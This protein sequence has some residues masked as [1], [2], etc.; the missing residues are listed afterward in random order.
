MTVQSAAKAQSGLTIVE[1]LIAMV[2]S[3]GIVL[4]IFAFM[5]DF[6]RVNSTLKTDFDTYVV[7]LDAGDKLRNA[8]SVSSGLIIQ[9][10][11]ADTHTLVADTSEASGN[12][13]EPLHAIP[14][15][16]SI[17]SSGTY[18]PVVYFQ[19]PSI[20]SSKNIIFNDDQP[21]EDEYVLYLDGTAKKMMLRT[22][23]NPAAPGNTAVS[24]CPPSAVTA[25][26][27]VDKTVAMDISSVETRYFSRSGNPID[28]TSI[29]DSTSGEYIGPDF[30]VVEVIELTLNLYKKSVVDGGQDSINSTIVR[31]ALRNK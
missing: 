20:D 31:V 7:R 28:F 2:V 12:Y 17:G 18:T 16:V 26:C 10:S 30:P 29:I 24:S 19:S 1:L 15:T 9:N 13:W 11:I 23:A 14:S 5:L 8:F 25:S 27:P 22:I 3:M 4:V 6:W 21:Y